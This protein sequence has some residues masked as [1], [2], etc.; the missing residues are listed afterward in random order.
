[1]ADSWIPPIPR[2]PGFTGSETPEL[3]AMPDGSGF[4]PFVCASLVISSGD[5]DHIRFSTAGYIL[6]EL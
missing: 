6:K 1:L 5:R 3:I 2:S 4:A